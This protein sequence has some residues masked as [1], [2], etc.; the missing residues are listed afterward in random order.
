MDEILVQMLIMRNNFENSV[1][2]CLYLKNESS[3]DKNTT[4]TKSEKVIT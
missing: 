4:V 3:D 1:F 2:V